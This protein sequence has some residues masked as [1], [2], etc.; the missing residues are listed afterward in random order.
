[1]F[2]FSFFTF[3]FSCNS[4]TVGCRKNKL[5]NI[6][7]VDF[8]YEGVKADGEKISS[9][10]F[11]LTTGTTEVEVSIELSNPKNYSILN[12]ELSCLRM[13]W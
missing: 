12:F 8:S 7:V 9:N 10:E 11:I 1:M 3:S 13:M 2:T 4:N 5:D 6:D